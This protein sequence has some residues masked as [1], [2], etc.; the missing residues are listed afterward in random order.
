MDCIKLVQT[1]KFI[2]PNEMPEPDEDGGEIVFFD[3]EVYS[4]LFVVCWK[5]IGSDTVVRM[6]N[7]TGEE[8]TPLFEQKLVGFNNRRYD[9]HILY[10][11]YLGYTLEGLFNLSQAIIYNDKNNNHSLFGEAYNL[12]YADIYEFSSIKTSLKKFQIMLGIHHQELDLP[13]DKPV[14]DDMVDKVV[15]YCVNDVIST[16]AVFKDRHQDF[17]ARKIL[18]EMSGLSVNDTTQRQAARI[19]FGD[20]REP[21]KQFVYTDLSVRFPRL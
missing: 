8:L 4:N 7:P 15:E 6:L 13:W 12:S 5:T 2:G 10:A 20:E 3:V 21:Q 9:N 16:E 19:I 1:M 17:A 18:C 11:R 14:P